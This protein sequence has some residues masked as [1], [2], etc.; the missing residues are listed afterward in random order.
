MK[1]QR[2]TEGGTSEQLQER[3]GKTGVIRFLAELRHTNSLGR[4]AARGG[5]LGLPLTRE[6]RKLLGAD[7]V[8][9]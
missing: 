8:E 6:I 4:G 7:P 3:E 1:P 2:A 9:L 5:Y